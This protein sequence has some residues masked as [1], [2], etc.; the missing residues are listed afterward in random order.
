V[1]GPADE[2]YAFQ[3]AAEMRPGQAALEFGCS[4][5]IFTTRF[6]AA[7]PEGVPV[8]GV[9]LYAPEVCGNYEF[10]H[11]DVRSAAFPCRFDTILC[12]SSFE[13]VGVE[14]LDFSERSLSAIL[15]SRESAVKEVAARL[16]SLLLP[17]GQLVVTCPMGLDE[18]FLVGE[19]GPGRPTEVRSPKWGWVGYTANSLAQVFARLERTSVQAWLRDPAKPYFDL[20]AW[21][22]C[23]PVP[24]S[25]AVKERLRDPK[26]RVVLAAT[27]IKPGEAACES[28]PP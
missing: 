13:H 12:V 19:T 18:I 1:A 2:H 22:P 26:H 10:I 4:P 15:E 3:Y 7:V 14:S 8:Y 28:T 6:A 24:T 17:G 23:S 5:G 21:S 11:G 20:A 25:D 16:T 9:D 27:F